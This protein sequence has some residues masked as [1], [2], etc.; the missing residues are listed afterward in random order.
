MSRDRPAERALPDGFAFGGL[1]PGHAE[2]DQLVVSSRCRRHGRLLPLDVLSICARRDRSSSQALIYRID[3]LFAGDA[4]SAG[5]R[6]IVMQ[7][8]YRKKNRR[9]LIVFIV[10]AVGFTV[11]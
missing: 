4:R 3:Y 7:E 8:E 5:L 11:L 6:Q 2:L 1:S 9:L 10:F